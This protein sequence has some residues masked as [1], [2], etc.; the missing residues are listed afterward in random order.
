[1]KGAWFQRFSQEYLLA[2][3]PGFVAKGKFLFKSPV[4]SMFRGFIFDSSGFSKEAFYPEVYVQPLYVPE[5]HAVLT[6]GVR[7]TGDWQARPQ[8][9]KDL[10]KKLLDR[11]HSVGLPFLN[12]LGSPEKLAHP[13][14][15]WDNSENVHVQQAIA[16]SLVFIGGDDRALDRIDKICRLLQAASGKYA[17]EDKLLADLLSFKAILDEDPSQARQQLAKWAE[18]TRGHLRLPA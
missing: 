4:D 7:F 14:A 2:S 1:M 5:K 12:S 9:E 10:A 8:D 17:W 18:E 6:L 11:I 13:P 15:R 16:Y 3:L